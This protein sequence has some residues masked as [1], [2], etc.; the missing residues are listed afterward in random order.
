MIRGCPRRGT[1]GYRTELK[2]A[3]MRYPLCIEQPATRAHLVLAVRSALSSDRAHPSPPSPTTGPH[4]RHSGATSRALLLS[5]VPA[6]SAESSPESRSASPRSRAPPCRVDRLLLQLRRHG[7]RCGL[8]QEVTALRF[9]AAWQ[10][11][12]VSRLVTS[13]DRL[14]CLPHLSFFARRRF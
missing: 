3:S 14:L 2:L 6:P 12:Q 7:L 13:R 11:S 5:R 8:N 1:R 9:L 10:C 4:T